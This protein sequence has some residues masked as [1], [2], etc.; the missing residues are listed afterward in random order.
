MTGPLPTRALAAL[1]LAGCLAALSAGA[2]QLPG[3]PAHPTDLMTWWTSADTAIAFGG[4]L[5][6]V[7]MGLCG[8]LLLVTVVEL[9]AVVAGWRGLARWA[10]RAAPAAWRV[11]VLRPV[12]AGTLALPILAPVSMPVVAA[13]TAVD[14]GPESDSAGGPAVLTMTLGT[15]SEDS[16]TT[17]TEPV[18]PTTSPTVI[19]TIPDDLHDHETPAVT[20]ST[21]AAMTPPA[22]SPPTPSTPADDGP[23]VSLEVD[24]RPDDAIPASDPDDILAIDS[25]SYVVV[26]GD[27]FWRIAAVR[28][29][30][31]LGR[32]PEPSEIVAYWTRLVAANEDRLPVP[33]NADLI[34]PGDE[35]VL[36]GI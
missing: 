12:T 14:S 26:P 5:R 33:G 31:S 15:H 7:A 20:T 28:V 13:Q 18:D 6:I 19:V 24:E 17:T 8:W 2:T 16:A 29:E 21:S 1:A 35:V 25:E 10:H 23:A 9:V 4:V 27:S 30:A 32:I 22:T 36:P 11:L 34:F 3:P